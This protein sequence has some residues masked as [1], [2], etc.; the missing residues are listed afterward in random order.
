M[1]LYSDNE[2]KFH[3]SL[4]LAQLVCSYCSILIN[5]FTTV[6]QYNQHGTIYTNAKIIYLN[7]PC[8]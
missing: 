2:G 3:T 6:K 7:I 5:I 1:N 8:K 4:T